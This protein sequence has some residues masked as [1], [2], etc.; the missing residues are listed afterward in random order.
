[1]LSCLY[2]INVHQIK[3]FQENVGVYEHKGF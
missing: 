3:S 1:M 2:L